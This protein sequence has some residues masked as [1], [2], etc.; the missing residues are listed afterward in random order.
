MDF[1]NIFA[2]VGKITSIHTVL[3]IAARMD[4]EVEL[5]NVQTTFL[6]G[7]LVEEIYMQ[8]L[9]GFVEKGKV[10]LVCRLKKI[11]YGLKQKPRQGYQKFES[12]MVDHGFHKMQADQCVFVKKYKG[13]DF[14][15][16]LLYVDNMLIV[17]QDLKKIGSLKKALGKSFVIKDIGPTK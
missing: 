15:I 13:G 5:L 1:E 2:L 11:L 7:D 4:L 14:L 17:G 12:F 16:L 8:H 10:N 3:S 9:E 6:Y